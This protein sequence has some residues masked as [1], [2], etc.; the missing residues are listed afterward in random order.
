MREPARLPHGTTRRDFLA[1]TAG[2]A[3]TPLLGRFAAHAAPRR[4]DL[5]PGQASARVAL[6][7]S[8]MALD[9]PKVHVAHTRELLES[10][11]M[12]LTETHTPRDAW[13][14]IVKPE[15]IIGLKFNGSGQRLIGT[16]DAMAGIIVGSLVD[17]G[18]K[19]SRLVCIEA[20]E[21]TTL[22]LGTLSATRGFDRT[23]T[24]FAS[25]EDQFASWLIQVTAII[26]IPFLKTH[27]IC[28]L[29]CSLKNLS[30]A[31]VKHPARFH[32]HNCSPYIPDIVAAPIIREKLRLAIVDALRVVYVDGPVASSRNLSDAGG[33]IV[34]RDLV[35]TDAVGLAMLNDVRQRRDLPPIADSPED[36]P[37]LV[38]AHTSGLGI[39][40]PHGIDLLRIRS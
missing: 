5:A 33:I 1:V 34:G 18:W 7:R 19:A 24:R 32:D 28:T 21:P 4:L 17:A 15:D 10:S 26:S 16:S 38:A 25:G 11:L 20:P 3:S 12:K 40:A 8:R 35:A 2:I 29:T 30:H 36:V 23:P 37:Y 13:H 14:A 6:A 27:N 39:A 22:R 31:A 9:G